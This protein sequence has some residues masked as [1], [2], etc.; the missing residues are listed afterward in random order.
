MDRVSLFLRN[1]YMR[2]HEKL[3]REALS[4]SKLCSDRL[5]H[6]DHIMKH[7]RHLINPELTGEAILTVGA[8]LHEVVDHC[9]GAIAIGPFGCMPN[10]LA[11]SI[12]AREMNVDGKM[13][14]GKKSRKLLK[15]SEKIHDLPFLAIES[16]GN[17]FPQIITAK[18]EAFLLQAG[19]LHDELQAGEKR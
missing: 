7:T 15:L 10:R 6:V 2:R 8:V 14:A 19:R 11:E 1:R 17:R 5:E 18:L 9:C 16:D 3:F 4:K 12:L 13:N